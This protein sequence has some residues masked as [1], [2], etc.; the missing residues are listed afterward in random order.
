[1]SEWLIGN[2]WIAFY[3]TLFCSILSGIK[4]PASL[5]QG[6]L[7]GFLFGIIQH[8]KLLYEYRYVTGVLASIM[9]V[10]LNSALRSA[11]HESMAAAAATA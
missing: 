3:I 9:K 5:W 2:V 8:S 7:G 6:V 1:M 10:G 11:T 4:K